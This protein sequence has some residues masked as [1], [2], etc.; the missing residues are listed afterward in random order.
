M[1]LRRTVGYCV[2][3]FGIAAF[4]VSLPAQGGEDSTIVGHVTDATGASGPRVLITAASPSLI[5]GARQ[6]R[7]DQAGYYR[8]TSLTPGTYQIQA[9]LPGF[10]TAVQR[11]IKLLADSTVVIDI[12]LVV[13]GPTETVLVE[14]PPS[15]VD[16]TSA[17]S[18]YRF[19]NELIA[20]LPTNRVLSDVM[21][22]APGVNAGIGLG[23]VQGSNPTFVEGVNTAEAAFLHPMASFNYNWVDDVQ[24]IGVG[25]GAE[26]GEFSGVLQKS[27]LRAGGNRFHGLVEHRTSRPGWVSTNTSSLTP[28]VESVFV[29]QSQRT[30]TWRDTS[31]QL[32]GPLRE[33]RLWFFAGLQQSRHDVVPALFTGQGSIDERDR[34]WLVKLDGAPAR[35]L[36]LTGFF[37]YDRRRTTGSGL[38]PQIPLETTTTDTLGNHSSNARATWAGT[39]TTAEIEY[40]GISGKYSYDPT[41]PATR[42]GPYPHYDVETGRISGNTTSYGDFGGN[43]R[44][45]GVTVNDYRDRLWGRHHEL[46]FGLQHERARSRWVSG[47]PGGRIYYDF[48]GV[49]RFVDLQEETQSR[50]DAHRTTIFVQDSWAARAGVT[51]EPGVRLTFNRGKVSQGAVLS[52]HPVSPRMGVAWDV[53]RDHRTVLRGHFGR[54]HDALLTAQYSVLDEQEPPALITGLVVGPDQFVELSRSASALSYTR[55]PSIA[56]PYFDQWVAGIEHQLPLLTALTVQVIHRTYGNLLGYTDLGSIYEPVQRPDPGIDG[57]VGTQDDSAPISMFQKTNPGQEQFNLTNLSNAYRRYTALQLI[58]QRQQGR[59]WQFQG[60]YTWS[61]SRGT[62]DNGMNSNASG[63]DLGTNGI[64]A[65]PN[66]AINADGPTTFDFTHEVKLLGTWRLPQWGGFNVSTVYQYHTGVAWGRTV[67]VPGQFVTFGVRVEP[68]GTRRTPALSTIDLRFEKTFTFG[69]EGR[70]GI[71]ADVLNLANQGIPDPSARRPVITFSG[72]AFGQP[73]FWLTPRTVHAAVRVSF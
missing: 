18:P 66:R 54:Y 42:F 39:S 3:V 4:R 62:A 1:V 10:T 16:V 68:R 13:A 59:L 65:D 20:N 45:I 44:V 57:R 31:A 29:S 2:L 25:A 50:S 49:P 60:S 23:G 55:D 9:A 38:G 61:R 37:E 48:N 5:G 11:D 72:P 15:V 67:L 27:R 14:G 64:G 46:M 70:V 26:Y 52:T 58:G 41:L 47:F 69:G 7:T 36:R 17:Q 22:L 35:S 6:T 56:P 33:D 19:S 28:S 30:L 63:P 8:V 73:Q 53:G 71:F 34:R 21:N 51:L 24:V 32:G 12:T 40:A 43:R